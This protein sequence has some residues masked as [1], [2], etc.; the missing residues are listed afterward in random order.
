MAAASRLQ[1]MFRLFVLQ[2]KDGTLIVLIFQDELTIPISRPAKSKIKSN[3]VNITVYNVFVM[4][5]PLSSSVEGVTPY[6]VFIN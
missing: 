1:I 2:S 3:T 6:L 4:S 5:I